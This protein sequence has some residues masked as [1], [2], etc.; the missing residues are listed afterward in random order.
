MRQRSSAN[1]RLSDVKRDALD[2]DRRLSCALGDVA[3]AEGR[4]TMQ[5]EK[6]AAL[7]RELEAEREAAQYAAHTAAE[8]AEERLKNTVE[9][10]KARHE[11]HGRSFGVNCSRIMIVPSKRFV[12]MRQLPRS[13]SFIAFANSRPRFSVT[14]RM[15]RRLGNSRMNVIR[16]ALRCRANFR[17]FERGGVR[18]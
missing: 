11:V 3:E 18:T 10:E 5:S 15:L 9:G 16:S 6:A 17:V 7:Q 1:M 12:P 2:T 4:C 14:P 8:A 13:A